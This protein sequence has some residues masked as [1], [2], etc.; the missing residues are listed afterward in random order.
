[1]TRPVITPLEN[2]I[3]GKIGVSGRALTRGDIESHQLHRL[4][5]TLH[6][7]VSHSR[8]YAD[9]LK[10]LP[11]EELPSCRDLSHYPFT[12]A[13]DIRKSP[14]SFL[15]V[16]QGEIHRV[17]TLDTSGT[18]G[19]P[20]RLYFTRQDQELTVDFFH[21]G[22]STL[23][24]PGDRV[25]ILLPGERPGS[26]GDLLVK[27][28]A[29]MGVTGVPHGI[30]KDVR[31][32][33]RT[34]SDEHI[35]CLVGI[36]RQVLSLAREGREAGE[37]RSVLL[38][39][40]HV[41][42]AVAREIEQVWGCEVFGHYGM[43]EMG[44]GG[45]VECKAH[46]G[47]HLREA[48]LYVEMVHPETGHPVPDGDTGEVVFTT[49]TRNGMPL[50]R[51]RTGDLSRF[52]PS[53]CPCG[54]ILKTME[55][56]TCRVDGRFDL[57]GGWVLTLADLDEALFALREVLDFKAT[58]SAEQGSEVLT[59]ELALRDAEVNDFLPRVRDTLETVSAIRSAVE[60]GF[61]RVRT[62]SAPSPDTV[63]CGPVKRTLVD[64]R[65]SRSV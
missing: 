19:L 60:S 54:T 43:T 7:A 2:W 29:R 65:K 55:R 26:V 8:F 16:P 49:L 50:I 23:V 41:P 21:H 39:T 42:R 14:L 30:V 4:R 15:C 53:P 28:L 3:A 1:M 52:I 44:L 9:R 6:R 12:T 11:A 13:D 34:L 31:E 22:M 48:D 47:Y 63:P 57:G 24:Q 36:P 61:L 20:K 62:T 5:E 38:S 25:L 18:T 32:T 27:G 10:G 64:A 17:V 58:L 51:Y 46:S 59:V 33:L 35:T 56:V 40:D 45:G 37:L